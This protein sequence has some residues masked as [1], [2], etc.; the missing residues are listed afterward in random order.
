MSGAG[1][2]GA[3]LSPGALVRAGPAL[4]ALALLS[5]CEP[6]RWVPTG[7]S[8][9]PLETAKRICKQHAEKKAT[10]EA[11]PWERRREPEL[12]WGRYNREFD[13]CMR[14]YG[15]VRE[16]PAADDEGSQDTASRR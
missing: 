12:D 15:Y 8:H 16:E 3:P 1:E 7:T 14:A 10:R 4:L 5:G 6:T 13:R 11:P 9:Y 2:P